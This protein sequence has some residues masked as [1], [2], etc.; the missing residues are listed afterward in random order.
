[1]LTNLHEKTTAPTGIIRRPIGEV[2]TDVVPFRAGLQYNPPARGHW[3]I[4]HTPIII[5]GCHI[6]FLCANACM[7]GVVMSA[8]EYKG[9]DRFSMIMLYDKDIYD[10]RLEQVMI[11]GISEIIDR[12]PEHPPMVMPFTSCI[13]HFLAYDSKF[14]YKTLRERYPDIDFVQSYM[15]PTIRKGTITPEEMIHVTMYE[16]LEKQP[17]LEPHAVNIIGSNFPAQT[18]ND[19]YQ[20]LKAAGWTIR[21]LPASKVYQEYK[22]MAKSSY[23]LYAY[24][25]AHRGARKLQ[26][27][28]GQEG[29]YLPISCRPEEIRR[30][31]LELAEKLSLDLPDLT[32]RIDRMQSEAEEA[33]RRA[34]E[35][36]GD[37]WI[38]LDHEVL[39]RYCSLAR[40][41]VE[42][43]FN[44]KEI[45]GD[46]ILPEEADDLAWL[47][48]NA[49]EIEF[50]A[51][52]N[53]AARMADRDTAERAAK[54]GARVVAIGQKSAYF[55]GTDHFVNWIE[56]AGHWGF[57]GIRALAEQLIEAY[58]HASDV[59][60]IIQIKG[61]GCNCN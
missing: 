33:L 40:L 50:C 8:M 49:P 38:A 31:L 17:A 23:N 30:E 14:I 41:L 16:A 43:G 25:V 48:E 1:M 12:Q 11:E 42:N 5:P 2:G 34:K 59:P 47:Q 26:R 54:E 56:Y 57:N 35:V 60:A 53:Y 19:Y 32:E 6:V 58:E 22:D 15:I 21:D 9:M 61:W 39:P 29:I 24:P 7:R 27:R 36:L 13:H 28:L 10:G 18:D 37:S 51:T 55:T 3:T 45:Y 52:V 44:V 4:A 46:V 20:I